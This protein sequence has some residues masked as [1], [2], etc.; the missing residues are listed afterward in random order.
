MLR[1]KICCDGHFEQTIICIWGRNMSDK[2]D[3]PGISLNFLKITLTFGVGLAL[4]IYI[5]G[6]WG[7]GFLD[8]YFGTKP[9]ITLIGILLAIFLS[10]YKLITALPVKTKK[11]PGHQAN[12]NKEE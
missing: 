10:F 6:V 12:K 3:K 2:P 4:R 8:N 9:F 5:L 11:P 1:D 7:G